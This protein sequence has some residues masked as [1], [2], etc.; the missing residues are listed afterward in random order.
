MIRWCGLFLLL[1]V[2]CDQDRLSQT[3]TSEK[4]KSHEEEE[5]SSSADV[6]NNQKKSKKQNKRK[7]D[8]SDDLLASSRGNPKDNDTDGNQI[9]DI[10]LTKL[11][12]D[13]VTIEGTSNLRLI[14]TE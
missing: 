5:N 1:L 10:P 13:G 9:N 11:A 8:L 14:P 3:L 2:A 12:W 7:S 4:N 6:L